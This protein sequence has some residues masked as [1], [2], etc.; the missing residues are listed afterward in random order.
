MLELTKSNLDKIC[1]HVDKVESSKYEGIF[2]GYEVIPPTRV[3]QHINTEK[4]WPEPK[5]KAYFQ[6]KAVD[7]E[8]D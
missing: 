4:F 2:A 3:Q 5:L 1:G 6:E 8:L 7:D